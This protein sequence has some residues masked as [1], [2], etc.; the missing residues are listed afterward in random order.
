MELN[1]TSHNT[2]FSK[3]LLVRLESHPTYFAV[4]R[5][6]KKF[7]RF[8]NIAKLKVT[9]LSNSKI[10]DILEDISFKYDDIKYYSGYE[11]IGNG[12][13]K[14]GI[15][16]LLIMNTFWNFSEYQRIR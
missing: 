8:I 14:T 11:K 13:Q 9:N 1:F 7:H 3:Y 4:I 6:N 15:K 12:Y 16:K 10:Y 5:L 2:I